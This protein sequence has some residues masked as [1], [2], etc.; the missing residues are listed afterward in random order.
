M[1]K[2]FV[3]KQVIEAFGEKSQFDRGELHSLLKQFDPEITETALS[4]RIHDFLSR[5]IIQS[6][7]RGVYIIADSQNY[8]PVISDQLARLSRIVAKEFEIDYCA[9]TS[10]WLN[11]LTRHQ[12][13]TYFFIIEVERDFVEEVFNAY[14]ESTK[15]RVFLDP[16]KEIME[17]YVTSEISIIIKPLISR[18]PRQHLRIKT[19]SSDRIH[20]P[21]L[22]KILVDVFCDPVTFYMVQGTEMETLFENALKRYHINYSRLLN[23]ARRRKKEARIKAY[24]KQ[25]FGDLLHDII[26]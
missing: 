16:N 20:V 26:E 10:E 9:W 2:K 15:F 22:E 4:W 3:D 5:N 6:I 19:K 18:S 17:R 23:Y 21:T 25:Y 1:L 13:G 14:S 7:K 11:D 8:I 24:L 12:I